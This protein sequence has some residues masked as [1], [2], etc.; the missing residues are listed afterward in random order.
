MT[1]P[2]FVI[3]MQDIGGAVLFVLGLFAIA[4]YWIVDKIKN[5][6]RK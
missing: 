3:T 6:R 4:I 2:V 1:E 5:G